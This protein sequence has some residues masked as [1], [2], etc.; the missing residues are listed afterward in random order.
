VVVGNQIQTLEEQ[1]VLL[2]AKPSLQPSF[3]LKDIFGSW[4]NRTVCTK[5]IGSK[6][7]AQK[8][9]EGPG[10]QLL[11]GLASTHKALGSIPSTT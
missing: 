11:E 7:E 3:F 5:C 8:P 4:D 6:R 2:A 1:P 9:Q 10:V